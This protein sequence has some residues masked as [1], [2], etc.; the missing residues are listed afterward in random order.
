M[1][2]SVLAGAAIG[3]GGGVLTAGLMHGGANSARGV[4]SAWKTGMAAAR[5]SSGRWALVG[6]LTGGAIA[7]ALALTKSSESNTARGR[8]AAAG[9]VTAPLAIA[10]TGAVLASLARGQ[11]FYSTRP[12]LYGTMLLAGM[13]GAAATG[14][15]IGAAVDAFARR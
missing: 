8:T 10:G 15:A 3:A 13:A 14:T 1:T 12:M 6:A 5:A 9:L 4:A 7:G 2:G 11:G